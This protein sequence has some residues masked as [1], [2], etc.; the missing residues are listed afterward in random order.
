MYTIK[1]FRPDGLHHVV[2]ILDSASL[3]LLYG[4][5]GVD[6]LAVI[7]KLCLMINDDLTGSINKIMGSPLESIQTSFCIHIGEIQVT[8]LPSGFSVTIVDFAGDMI[9]SA[10][11]VSLYQAL[12]TAAH[13]VVQL[14]IDV[15][16]SYWFRRTDED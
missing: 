2:Q 14:F 10:S 16:M 1:V 12:Y 3:E 8:K 6:L 11:S 15:L 7:D 4:H 5:S 9:S 13:N